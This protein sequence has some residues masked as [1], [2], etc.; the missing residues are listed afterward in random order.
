MIDVPRSPF[1]EHPMARGDS[2]PFGSDFDATDPDTDKQ[3]DVLIAA[4]KPGMATEDANR[5]INDARHL[6]SARLVDL[7]RALLKHRDMNV[8]GYAL[9]LLEGTDSP[10]VLPAVKEALEDKDLPVRLQALE[11]L[12]FLRHDE[13]KA[14]YR[15]AITDADA[16]VRMTAFTG[17]VEQDE[18]FR[19]EIVTAGV[20]SPWED[21]A[22]A[23]LAYLELDLTPETLPHYFK[24]LDHKHPLVKTEASERLSMLFDKKFQNS[25]EANT[26]W[27]LNQHLYTPE[28]VRKD[29]LNTLPSDRK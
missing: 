6:R 12:R 14:I 3:I 20:A 22:Q 26:W 28:L 19:R 2:P 18:A 10:K 9:T 17:A 27:K 29:F 7:V 4:V 25:T 21:V 11:V 23:S 24:A 1:V 16:G 13:S 5:L 15:G 8:R